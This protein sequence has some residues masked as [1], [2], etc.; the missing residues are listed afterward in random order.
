MANY[1]FAGIE[2][3]YERVMTREISVRSGKA[4]AVSAEFPFLPGLILSLLYGAGCNCP[5][6]LLKLRWSSDLLCVGGWDGVGCDR[7]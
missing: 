7:G 5:L 4:P 2:A 6:C 3:V 1:G